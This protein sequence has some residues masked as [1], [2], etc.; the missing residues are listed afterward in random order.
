MIKLSVAFRWLL[1]AGAFSLIG[2]TLASAASAGEMT[3]AFGHLLIGAGLLIAAA[4]ASAPELS[5]WVSLPFTGLIDSIYLGADKAER[6]P[7]NYNLPRYYA[8]TL[9]DDLAIGCYENLI[10]NYPQEADAYAELITVLLR[11]PERWREAFDARRRARR[12]LKS[13]EGRAK[14]EEAFAAALREVGGQISG[15]KRKVSSYPM[16]SVLMA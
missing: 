12:C 5:R 4:I 8:H 11:D 2:K 6:P 15:G 13:K 9:R 1:A 3:G 14:V 16:R 10:E 7:P